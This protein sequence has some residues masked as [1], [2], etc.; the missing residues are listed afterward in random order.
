MVVAVLIAAQVAMPMGIVQEPSWPRNYHCVTVTEAL[1]VVNFNIALGENTITSD[2][3]VLILP[4]HAAVQV[5]K[6]GPSIR[7]NGNNY[8]RFL[9]SRDLPSG[10]IW[11]TQT[12]SVEAPLTQVFIDT[13]TKETLPAQR[14]NQASGYCVTAKP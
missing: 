2:R 11:I 9:V 14:T 12:G 13:R 7:S 8:L 5:E 10:K 4:A 1:E 3:Q 6:S